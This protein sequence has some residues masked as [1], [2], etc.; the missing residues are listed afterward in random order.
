[1]RHAGI[2]KLPKDLTVGGNL[3]IR[4]T[5]ITELPERLTVGGSLDIRYTGITE[6]PERL[7]V[8]GNLYMDYT[9]TTKLPEGLTVGRD[10]YWNEKICRSPIPLRQG[11]YVP[12]RY[13]YA[14]GILTHVSNKKTFGKYDVYVGKIKG[15]NVVSDGTHYAHCDTIRDG[16]ADL[17]F[18]E[19][20]S[21]GAEQYSNL[22][23]DSELTPDEAIIMYRVITGACRQGTR[24]FVD[25]LRNLKKSYSIEEI[26]SLT[27]GQYGAS[28]F[29]NFFIW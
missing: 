5:G 18:K 28:Q 24:A 16:I 25:S 7:T 17:R 27:E 2:K 3:D 9:E 6:L 11:D 10:I 12:G 13:L 20:E 1:M 4:Y 22:T 26:I 15:R 19:I 14:D 8:G 29:K 23:L 21:R